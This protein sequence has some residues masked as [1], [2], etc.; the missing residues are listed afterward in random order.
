MGQCMVVQAVFGPDRGSVYEVD[1]SEA[2]PTP[3]TVFEYLTPKSLLYLI[4]RGR[5][6]FLICERFSLPICLER[7]YALP[8]S[9][10]WLVSILFC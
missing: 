3:R 6:V 10:L 2:G 8:R 7:L 4:Q 9:F 5:Y 1:Q